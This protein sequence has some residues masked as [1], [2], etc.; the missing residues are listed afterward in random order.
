[1]FSQSTTEEEEKEEAAVSTL[2]WLKPL[3]PFNCVPV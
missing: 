1:M 3:L 2:K